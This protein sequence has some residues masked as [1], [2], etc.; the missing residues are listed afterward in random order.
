MSQQA[1]CFY[2]FGPYRIDMVERV[3]L[4]GCE[5][6]RLAPKVFET[7]VALVE[8]SGHV[9]T[10][11]ELMGRVWPDCFVE[12]ANLAVNVSSLRKAL[13]QTAGGE[14]YIETVAKRG[15]RFVGEVRELAAQP[16]GDRVGSEA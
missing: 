3:L 11:D 6:V 8:R 7:L 12:E 13:S 9:V 2:S 5:S 15:Y 1:R 10:K 14:Q 16:N 4:C